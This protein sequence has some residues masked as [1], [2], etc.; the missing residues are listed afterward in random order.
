M[1]EKIIQDYLSEATSVPVLMEKPSPPPARYYIIEKTG[2]G[3]VDTLHHT[4]LNVESHAPTLYETVQLHDT[5]MAAM[6]QADSLAAV[7]KVSLNTEYNNT[8]T[9]TKSYQYE[10]VYEVTHFFE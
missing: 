10:A 7:S 9:E 8:D 2:G 5:A 6:L 3:R 1:I 4:M